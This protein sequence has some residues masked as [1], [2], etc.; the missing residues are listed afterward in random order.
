MVSDKATSIKS[1]WGSETSKR[2]MSEDKLYQ[3]FL[4]NKQKMKKLNQLSKMSNPT[5]AGTEVIAEIEEFTLHKCNQ[6]G[7][8]FANPRMTTSATLDY[9]SQSDIGSYFQMVEASHLE[10]EKSS[11]LPLLNSLTD[12]L[13]V[14]AKVLEVGC[15]SGALLR[16]LRDRGGYDVCGVE[17]APAAQ[18]YHLQH[19]LTVFNEPIET[20]RSDKKFDVVL[21]WSVLDHLC[22]PVKALKSCYDL[23]DNGGLI[24]VGSVNTDGFDHRILGFDSVTFRPPGRVNYYNLS[25]L[26]AHLTMAG[27]KI[28][29]AETPG[30]LDVDI[31]KEYCKSGAVTGLPPFFFRPFH[32]R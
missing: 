8:I 2:A 10:R 32:G 22:D 12:R 18:K 15:G 29:S 19:G 28:E 20:F 6:T 26:K 14:G 1:F 11:Y 3:W 13:A 9:F 21:M 5:G 24:F 23:L 30:W 31:V 27:F 16:T 17:I 4:T 25:S 7:F